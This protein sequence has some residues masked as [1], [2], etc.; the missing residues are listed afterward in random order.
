MRE[1]VAFNQ[2]KMNR[3]EVLSSKS[4]ESLINPSSI[5]PSST[6][7]YSLSELKTI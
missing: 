7:Y 4:R 6:S 3:R 1:N 5:K 2:L